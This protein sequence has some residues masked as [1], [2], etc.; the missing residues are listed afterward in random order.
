MDERLQQLAKQHLML[1]FTDMHALVEEGTTIIDR[2]E[3]VYVFDDSGRRYIDGLS[4][5]YCVNVGHSHGEEIA[6]AAAAQMTRLPFTTNW[7]VAHPPAIELAAKLAE[8]APGALDRVFFTS[9]GSESVES[10]WKMA[11]QFHQANGEP[12]RR[13]VIARQDAYHGVTMGALAMTGLEECRTPFE[14][15]GVPAVHVANT[16]AYRHPEGG[17]PARLRDALLAEVEETIER[18]GADTIAML[19]AEPVQNAGGCLVPP[20]GYWAGL[21]RLCDRHGILLVSDEVICAFGRIGTWFG[22]QRLGYE[23]DMITFAKGLTGAH[24]PMGGLLIS[25]R[26]AA[27]FLEGKEMY[28]HGITF[29]GHPVGAAVAS[30]TLEIYERENV[31]DNVMA[32]EPHLHDLLNGL[33]DIPIVGDVR[34]I[35]HF[36]AIEL[37][38]DQETKEPFE[39][40]AAE[41]L[42]KDVLSAEL[43]G[44]GLI[45]R[46]DD[47]TDP[48]V[49]IAPPLVA[50]R[51]TIEEIA[52]ILR[53]GLT[54]ATERMSERPE[55]SPA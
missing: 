47:R 17:D 42:L 36:W 26:V 19:I 54:V 29:G 55:L 28:L 5:L 52:Q 39:G 45:C 44:R 9:G 41:W 38:R 8:L 43:W 24:F 20:D 3:G 33:R 14:P 1:H 48:I 46:L 18:E 6:A 30:A 31:M 23:P 53:E 22:A 25:E 50:D 13:K 27:P 37:V 7:T 40:P 12:A 49:Q 4:G 51:E 16:N 15:F 35:G 2:G 10:A 34:G 21:R 11:V 32:N